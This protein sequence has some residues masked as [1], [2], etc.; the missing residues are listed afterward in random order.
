MITRLI[1]FIMVLVMIALAGA[2][3]FLA[4]SIFDMT[5]QIHIEPYVFQPADS[6]RDR[7]GRPVP[8]ESLDDQ[9]IFERLV[10]KFLREYFSV[11]PDTDDIARRAHPRGNLA[12][13]TIGSQTPVFANWNA[14]VRPELESI[15]IAGQMR[16]VSMRDINMVGEFYVVR[17]NLI[18]YNPNDIDGTPYVQNR[19]LRMRIEYMPGLRTELGGRPLDIRRHM[20]EGVPVVAFQFR[21]HEVI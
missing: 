8:M 10:A 15:A 9:F 6:S 21:V 17:F 20:R 1:F 19:E 3:V 13:M 7:I 18:T 5:R 16:R 11:I 2:S 12:A 14:N 4:G